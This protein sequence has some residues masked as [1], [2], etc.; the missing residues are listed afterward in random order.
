VE[1]IANAGYTGKIKIGMDVAASEFYQVL[2]SLYLSLARSLA[3]SL[4]HTLSL[5]LSLSHTHKHTHTHT[6]SH[7]TGR[8]VQPGLQEPE[9]GPLHGPNPKP[10]AL[11]PTPENVNPTPNTQNS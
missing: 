11:N 2:S 4:T 7:T 9:L 3:L 6:L 5:S 1:A 10:E 8:Q